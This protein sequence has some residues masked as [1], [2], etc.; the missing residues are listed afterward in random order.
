VREGGQGASNLLGPTKP[1]AVGTSDYAQALRYVANKGE[2]T[3][4]NRTQYET[5]SATFWAQ[6][7]GAYRS[8]VH[9]C[10]SLLLIC[11]NRAGRGRVRK[12]Y[13]HSWGRWGGAG[14]E[15]ERKGGRFLLLSARVHT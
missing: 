5:D 10:A 12:R 2:K 9:T 4:G 15:I 1:Y 14:G 7:A 8:V 3:S 13:G 6:V 11:E